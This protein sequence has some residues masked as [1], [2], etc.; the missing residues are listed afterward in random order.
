MAI[1]E[2]VSVGAD[3]ARAADAAV[4]WDFKRR[5]ALGCLPSVYALDRFYALYRSG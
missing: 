2:A 3:G 4:Y 1:P 5:G